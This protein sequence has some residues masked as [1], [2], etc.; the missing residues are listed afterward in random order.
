MLLPQ[1]LESALLLGEEGGAGGGEEGSS[2]HELVSDWI[3][4]VALASGQLFQQK[5]QQLRVL[6][7]QGAVQVLTLAWGPCL[8]G[9]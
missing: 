7:P 9:G 4:R 1:L 8:H 6:T 3:D 5:L 2:S